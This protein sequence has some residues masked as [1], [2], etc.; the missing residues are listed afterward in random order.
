MYNYCKLFKYTGASFYCK[1]NK[2]QS[3]KLYAGHPKFTGLESWDPDHNLDSHSLFQNLMRGISNSVWCCPV[4]V[5]GAVKNSSTTIGLGLHRFGE[6]GS[7]S[8]P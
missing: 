4:K 7:R 6:L 3:N 2:Q 1:E 5:M 8:Q